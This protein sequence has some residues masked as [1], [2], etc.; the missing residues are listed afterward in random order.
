M[1][2]SNKWFVIINPT[3]GNGKAKKHWLKIKAKLENNEFEFDFQFTK[4]GTHNVKLVHFAVNKGFRNI[5]CIGGDGT[6]HNTINGIMSQETVFYSNISV[7]VI[8]IGTGNDW[9]KTYNIPRNIDQAINIIKNGAIAQQDIGKIEFID[10]KKLPVFFNNLAGIGFDGYVV[11][12]VGKYKHF[13]A[14]AYLIG[15]VLG[16]FSFKN[17][18]VEV[19]TNSQKMKTKSLMVLVGL[20]K[21]SGGGMQLTEYDSSFD[22]LF[23]V[24]VAKNF[25]KFEILKNI[26]KLFN[27]N[28]VNL[29]K[30]NSLKTSKITILCAKETTKPF[31]QADGELIGSESIKVSIIPKVFSFYAK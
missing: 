24:S 14:L 9:V 20:C 15:A 2:N 28:I 16:L 17:F 3:S 27:G 21:Y 4:S 5:I 10:S 6:I 18:E 25:S 30:V 11:S 22:G 19:I 29:N 8:P 23:D 31:I 26:F 1:S 13:G 12:K 7:G